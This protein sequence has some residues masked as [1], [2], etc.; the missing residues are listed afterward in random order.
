[1]PHAVANPTA[2][3][4]AELRAELP[5]AMAD[6]QLVAYFQPIVELGQWQALC[7]G[8]PGALA[9]PDPRSA[10][11]GAVPAFGRGYGAHAETDASDAGSRSSTA[12]K[13]EPSRS[14]R[15]G[16]RQ[17]AAGVHLGC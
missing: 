10:Q 11:P 7:R 3:S 1:M 14:Q 6:G 4:E 13:L 5:G 2:Q 15:P 16:R 9:A 17:R 12:G 8:S